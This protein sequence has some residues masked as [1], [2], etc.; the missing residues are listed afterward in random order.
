MADINGD[1]DDNTLNGTNADDTINGLGGDDTINGGAGNDTLYGDAGNSLDSSGLDASAL[2]LSNSNLVYDSSYGNN[3]AHPGDKAI[4]KNVA[5]LEDGTW[6]SARLVLVSTSDSSLNVDLSGGEGFEILLNSGNG[7]SK[8]DKGE[9]ATFR[10]EFFDPTTGDPVSINSTATFND[11][12][13]NS[14]GDVEAVSVDAASFTS[15]G[16]SSQT[17]LDVNNNGSSVVASGTETNSPDDQD[18]WFSAEFENQS[19][20]TFTLTTRSTQS[21]FSMNGDLI[22]DVVVTPLIPGNDII[23]G[24]DGNDVIYG[25]DGDD[26]LTAGAG[27]DL[28][29]GGE[30]NDTLYGGGEN[31]ELH[32]GNGADTIVVNS[33]G[34]TSNPNNT[35]VYGD[36][37][38]DATDQDTLDVSWFIENGYS[39]SHHV[40]NPDDDGNGF[41]GQ[42]TFHNEETG[43]T[44]NVNYN[45]IENF[46]ICFTPGTAIATPKGEVA[47]EMLKEGDRVFTRDNGVQE[48]R[49]VGQ[50]DVTQ[51]DFAG[52]NSLAPVMIQ[53][54]A[55][56]NGLPERDLMVSPQ[57]RVLLSSDRAQLYFEDREV[58]SPAIHLVGMPG[59]T[60]VRPARTSYIHFLCDNHEVVLSNGA[61]TETFQPGQASL[62]GLQ[63]AQRD[64]VFTLFPELATQHGLNNYESARKSLK[65]YET[66]LF[67]AS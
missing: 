43:E 53:K 5:Q 47:A 15:F 3:N 60:R 54:G 22:D 37:D 65:R 6:I 10:L 42:I 61:W 16:T 36:G 63:S 32:G 17:S 28:L 45:D 31:D 4:Y 59:I 18:A 23:D 27:Y 38:G 7:S 12:D 34:T 46:V 21:G 67:L 44:A 52:Q 11:I 50:K 20:I 1:N 62:Q 57:H 26:T 19:S 24:G 30:G 49:W 41:T 55:L 13:R 64:E 9:T 66:Q 25:E 2:T 8:Y 33:V 48:I 29:Y 51:T 56:G 39:I 58:L 14:V 40:Q 35:T